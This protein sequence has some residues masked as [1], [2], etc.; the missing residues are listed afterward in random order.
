M[1][2]SQKVKIINSKIKSIKV[3]IDYQTCKEVCINL[4]K[5]FVF[6]IPK[7]SESL[8]AQEVKDTTIVDK[9]STISKVKTEV[10]TQSTSP[11]EPKKKMKKD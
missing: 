8:I 10:K 2:L 7:I 9:N 6:E 4:N 11:K 5:K 1:V 3:V